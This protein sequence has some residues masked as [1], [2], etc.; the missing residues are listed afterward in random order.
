MPSFLRP[1]TSTS[2]VSRSIVAPSHS[3]AARSAGSSASIRS[4][5]FA[6]PDSVARHCW[7]V[8]RFASPAAVVEAS[9]GTGVN[10]WAATSARWRSSPTR[11][12]WPAG[13]AA[14][15]PTSSSPGPKPRSRCL[16]GPVAASSSPITSSR[17]SSSVTATIPALPVTLGSALPTRT[18]PPARF[19]KPLSM[20]ILLTRW[21]P[22]A[23]PDNVPFTTRIVPGRNG[24]HRYLPARVTRLL[25]ESGLTAAG[26]AVG[27]LGTSI[28]LIQRSAAR[29]GARGAQTGLVAKSA[30]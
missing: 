28:F 3:A 25:A 8:N 6:S 15:I 2:V 9:P 7:S 10:A 13:C 24:I 1:Y 26:L 29:R 22:S 30:N 11:K 23:P 18:R 14:A 20:R 17:S 5:T 19:P 4:L 21:V 27:V 16:I 12:S